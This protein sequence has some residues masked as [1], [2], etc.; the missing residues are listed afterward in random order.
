ME[1]NLYVYLSQGLAEDFGIGRG[2]NFVWPHPNFLA[3]HLSFY[4]FVAL[5]IRCGVRAT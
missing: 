2:V 4:F 5:R 1:D 3:P